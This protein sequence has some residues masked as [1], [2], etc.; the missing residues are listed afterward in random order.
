L[1]APPTHPQ[2]QP[3][4]LSLAAYFD[5]IGFTGA[6]VA[7]RTTLDALCRAHINTIPFEN[8]DVQLGRKTARTQ[9]EIHDKLVIRQR[10]GWC[11][12]Q[13]GLMGWVLA[14]IGFDV[15]PLCAGVLR[16]KLGDG[17]LGNHL[18][19]RVHL[20]GQDLLV[21]VGFGSSLLAPMNIAEGRR[22]DAP[23][24][25]GLSDSGDGYW[26]FWEMIGSDPFSFDFTANPA[27]QSVLDAKRIWQECDPD[28]NF[29]QNLVVRRRQDDRHHTLRG[30]V[31]TTLYPG[32]SDSRV[33]SNADELLDLLEGTF[34]LDVPEAASLW[35]VICARH[36][37]VFPD[38]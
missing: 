3:M 5:R 27:D 21:D 37:A 1:T 15:T 24:T 7:D 9:A 26:R 23:F 32:G 19:L 6:P 17:Q 36:A 10:G 4:S 38:A 28:S 31:F 12:E 30:K 20:D 33:L 34:D 18:C 13:N 16:D 8:I 14:E 11:Y 25:V 22:D 2:L 29:V 35:P